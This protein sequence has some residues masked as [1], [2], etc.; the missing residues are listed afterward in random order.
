[1]ELQKSAAVAPGAPVSPDGL[2]AHHGC[3]E[4]QGVSWGHVPSCLQPARVSAWIWGA[5]G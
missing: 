4:A 1:M 5:A 2:C 3:G